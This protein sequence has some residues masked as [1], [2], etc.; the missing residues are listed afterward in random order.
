[1]R[2]VMELLL[3]REPADKSPD[4][5]GQTRIWNLVTQLLFDLL[6]VW[7]AFVYDN[8]LIG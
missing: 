7:D 2:L 5:V 6:R 1:M 4:V 8:K 3:D